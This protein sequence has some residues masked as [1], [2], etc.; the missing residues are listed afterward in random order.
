MVRRS[1][2]VPA[3]MLTGRLDQLVTVPTPLLRKTLR[4]TADHL[5]RIR[6]AMRRVDPDIDSR[7]RRAVYTTLDRNWQ[8][9]QPDFQRL[10][11]IFER[12]AGSRM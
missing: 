11:R 7:L 1:E 10:L 6:T 2:P 8:S 4:W 5:P 12:P 9:Y 3:L